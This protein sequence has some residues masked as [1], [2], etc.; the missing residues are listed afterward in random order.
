MEATIME[1]LY[2]VCPVTGKKVDPGFE[3]ELG[4]LLKIRDEHVTA[5]CPHCGQHHTW[6]VGDAQ[7]TRPSGVLP[8]NGQASAS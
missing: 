3:S 6:T 2:F 5:D 7:L 4:T 8:D 1:R